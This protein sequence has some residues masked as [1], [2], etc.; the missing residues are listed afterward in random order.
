VLLFITE[1]QVYGIVSL[2]YILEL[3][4]V[5]KNHQMRRAASGNAML[6]AGGLQERAQLDEKV[7]EVLKLLV[8]FARP[9]FRS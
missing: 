7:K 3:R 1:V 9:Y 6:A 2:K 5:F 8:E 4:G